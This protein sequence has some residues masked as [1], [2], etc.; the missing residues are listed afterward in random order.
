MQQWNVYAPNKRESNKKK[1]RNTDCDEMQEKHLP[2]C[3]QR[4][5]LKDDT[6]K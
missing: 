3:E 5:L 1:M 6:K 4:E 2:R